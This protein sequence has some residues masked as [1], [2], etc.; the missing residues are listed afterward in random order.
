M[1]KSLLKYEALE[2]VNGDLIICISGTTKEQK[3]KIISSLALA[4]TKVGESFDFVK[5]KSIEKSWETFLIEKF[6]KDKNKKAIEDYLRSNLKKPADARAFA[7]AWTR[8]T[9][10]NKAWHDLLDYDMLTDEA[11]S[12]KLIKDGYLDKAKN[13]FDKKDLAKEGFKD[14]SS[15]ENPFDEDQPTTSAEATV[16]TEET[17]TTEKVQVQPKQ[18]YYDCFA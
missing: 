8:L 2:D 5:D 11:W 4:L 14:T 6:A 1:A 10:D 18:E 17:T 9:S 13:Y 7:Y 12:E 3:E 16:P 15:E